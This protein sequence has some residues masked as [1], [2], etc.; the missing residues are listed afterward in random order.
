MKA[1]EFLLSL[2]IKS[3]R[4]ERFIDEYRPDLNKIGFENHPLKESKG[5]YREPLITIKPYFL[6]ARVAGLRPIFHSVYSREC[7]KNRLLAEVSL[8]SVFFEL[9]CF[10]D[11][12]GKKEI[13]PVVMP[14]DYSNQSSRE[15]SLAM[16]ILR[17]DSFDYQS[18]VTRLKEAD[19][20]ILEPKNADYSC[21]DFVSFNGKETS[22]SGKPI[23]ESSLF[24]FYNE[25]PEC[26]E[27]CYR[28]RGTYYLELRVY[29]ID[30]VYKYII[31]SVIQAV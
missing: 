14:D 8:S 12:Y 19:S 30:Y 17:K 26:W 25:N 31:N 4:L 22:L 10:L 29:V 6:D 18:F 28:D 3:L 13:L 21:L 11:Q 2:G 9:A 5:I 7:Q 24:I 16:E 15:L 1:D 23:S 20:K 27:I